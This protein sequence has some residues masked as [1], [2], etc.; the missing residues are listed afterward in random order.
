MKIIIPDFDLECLAQILI[1]KWTAQGRVFKHNPQSGLWQFE[2]I[3]VNV[4]ILS[5][6]RGNLMRQMREAS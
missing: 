6:N 4:T 1:D 2:L 5:D 3:G